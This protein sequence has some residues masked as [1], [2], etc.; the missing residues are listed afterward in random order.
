M[1]YSCYS[2]QIYNTE[3]LGSQTIQ[4]NFTNSF[5]GNELVLS[6]SIASLLSKIDITGFSFPLVLNKTNSV[7]LT[8]TGSTF[9]GSSP[10][11]NVSYTSLDAT[12]LDLLFGDLPT[13]ASKTINITSTL[14]ASGCT[15]TIATAKGWTVIG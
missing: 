13:L 5:I 11:V 6:I 14:G 10:Q 4:S 15:R 3:Y 1:F 8:N 2:I 7:R 12:A 9:T